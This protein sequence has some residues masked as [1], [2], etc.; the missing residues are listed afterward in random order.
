MD[1]DVAVIG[2]GP[3]G[4]ACALFTSRFGLSTVLIEQMAVGGQLINLHAVKDYPGFAEGIA[5]WDL[6]AALTDQ[7]T[8]SGATMEFGSVT[9]IARA[10]GG[11][12]VSHDGGQLRARS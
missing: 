1:S 9:G 3:T 6:A 2:G 12:E 10:D 7:L 5:G 4:V 11:W 8:N